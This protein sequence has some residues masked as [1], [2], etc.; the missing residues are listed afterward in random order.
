[1]VDPIWQELYAN[2]QE[3]NKYP[4]HSVVSYVFRNAPRDKPRDQIKILEIGCGAGN[5]LWFAA[6]EGFQVTG[7]DASQAGIEYAKK[8][9]KE[10]GLT[11]DFY[12]GDFT[13]LPFENETFDL[14]IERAA[15]THT[16]R[17][18]AQRAINEVKRCLKPSGLVH[19]EIFSDRSSATGRKIDDNLMVEVDGAYSGHGQICFYSK[20]DIE[21][22]FQDGWSLEI[23]NHIENINMLSQPFTVLGH[24]TVIARKA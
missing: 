20:R 19:C 8:R 9:F 2:G 14:A 15:L 6:R 12:V 13:N 23:L 4:F 7:I 24:W 3:L 5:N 16:G 11:G 10:E 17:S 21:D 22:L 18:V 1:M